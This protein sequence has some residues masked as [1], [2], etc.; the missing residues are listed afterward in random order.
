[1]LAKA[2]T[3]IISWPSESEEFVHNRYLVIAGDTTDARRVG[4]VLDMY[5]FRQL[6]SPFR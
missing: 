4:D 2:S 3:R 1:M 5:A 6:S